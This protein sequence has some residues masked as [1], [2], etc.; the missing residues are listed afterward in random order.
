M[1]SYLWPQA[2]GVTLASL[3]T[4]L[5]EFVSAAE[6]PT[7][8]ISGNIATL[9]D[10][11]VGPGVLFLLCYQISLLED[12]ADTDGGQYLLWVPEATA[13]H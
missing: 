1:T 3:A 13:I 12:P 2:L 6:E 5:W 9:G 7:K 10:T 11:S 8:A 4:R